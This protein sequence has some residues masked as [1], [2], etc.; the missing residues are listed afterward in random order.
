MAAKHYSI[1]VVG[2]GCI[3][4]AACRHLSISSPDPS[5]IIGIGEAESTPGTGSNC[6]FPTVFSS[7]Y[8]QG[9][10]TRV[11][12]PDAVW[13]HLAA[14]S[15]SNY[16]EVEAKSGISFHGRV[17]FLRVSPFFG[18]AGDSLARSLEVGLQNG[19]E[20]EVADDARS[21]FPYFGFGDEDVAVVENGGAGY[22]NPR[23][24]VRAQLAIARENGIRLVQETVTSIERLGEGGGVK[25]STRRGTSFL[26]AR[27]LICTGA[28]TNFLLPKSL[29]LA[30]KIRAVSVVLAEIDGDEVKRLD[31]MPCFIWRLKSNPVL[32]S[33]YGCPPIQYPDGRT[34]VK[35]GGTTWQPKIVSTEEEFLEWFRGAG[36]K[37]E[38]DALL[39]VLLRELV[40]G[41][42]VKS[43]KTKP[44]V[45]SYAARNYPYMDKLSDEVFLAAFGCG[46]SA[47]SSDEIGKMASSLVCN[48][49]W[50]YDQLDSSLFRAVHDHSKYILREKNPEMDASVE[51]YH[52]RM[53]S[54]PGPFKKVTTPFGG[55]HELERDIAKLLSAKSCNR[56]G[57]ICAYISWRYA[58][59]ELAGV[60]CSVGR[61][62]S[63]NRL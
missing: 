11:V 52:A 35:I 25:I 46:A 5:T 59:W 41:L 15:I 36:C 7:H 53:W 8:D 3:G 1:A 47:K 13:S 58:C 17:G 2:L 22:V 39:E 48:G 32:H 56:D 55:L 19:A 50:S 44:C 16:P 28:Y 43:V 63:G 30:V 60:G 10:I 26:A 33:V 27:V 62:R 31:G 38:T 49:E 14:K 37:V 40:P 23:E 54:S 18:G 4:S 29:Q 6:S 51:I 24:M 20:A 12:D 45:V 57:G 42:R 34:Y 9:R 61:R 21:R